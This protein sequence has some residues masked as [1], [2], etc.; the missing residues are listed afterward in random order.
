MSIGQKKRWANISDEERKRL[1]ELGKLANINKVVSEESKLKLSNTRKKLIA[2]GKITVNN[3][4]G[5]KHSEETKKQ[6]SAS[7]TGRKMSPEARQKCKDAAKL[8]WQN[9]EY[10]DKVLAAKQKGKV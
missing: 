6:M 7:H 9:L 5:K 10:R 1:S 4:L 3:M 2:E 8:R